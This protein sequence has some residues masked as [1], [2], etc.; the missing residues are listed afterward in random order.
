[1]KKYIGK[2]LAYTLLVLFGVCTITFFVSR[3]IPGDPATMWVGPKH[4]QEQLDAARKELG[5]DRPLLVQ[6]LS[7]MGKLLKGDLGVSIRTKQPVLEEV[8]RRY[9]ATFELVSVSIVIALIIGIPLG[10]LSAVRKDR[11]LDHAS[12]A[13]SISGVAMPV[14]WLGL[15]LQMTL[16]GSLGWFPLQGRIGSMVL[17]DHPINPITGFYIFDSLV[18]GN[19]PA[20]IS[21]VKY[22]ALPALTMSFASLAVVTRIT[23]SSMLEVMREDYVQTATAYGVSRRTILYK[24]ALKNALIPT[25]TIIGLAYGLMLGG[26]VL[27][28]SIFDWPGLGSYIVL[29]ITRNDF[30]GI[31]G[32]TLVFAATYLTLNLIV[33]LIYYCVDPRIKRPGLKA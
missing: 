27:V 17:I 16:H 12:R 6:Y 5:L 1:M 19:W 26:S 21:A 20:F 32:S 30:P 2:R 11:P 10:V 14:F 7:Y 8:G 18:T 33:D 22:M 25:I 31:V 24:Y 23:R 28:E 3:I 13:F 4:T 29:S 9:A 15:I